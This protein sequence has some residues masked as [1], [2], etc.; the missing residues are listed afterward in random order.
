MT[1]AAEGA[2]EGF[3]SAHDPN[4]LMQGE[5]SAHSDSLHRSTKLENFKI[6]PLEEPHAVRRRKI[7]EKY[8]EITK[9]YR[10][11]IRS[12]IFCSI[13]VIIQ[14][15]MMYVVRDWSVVPLIL[16][17]YWVSGTLNHSLFLAMHE[18]THD[19][20]FESRWANKIFSYIVNIPMGVP[21][22]VY[23]RTYH[24]L[25]H[26]NL[27][28]LGQD[29]DIPSVFE[30]KIFRGKLGKLVW[31]CLQSATYCLR[32]LI[33]KPLPTTRAIVFATVF[34]YGLDLVILLTLG[35]KSLFYLFMG[36]I[37]GGAL[38]PIAGHFIAE[39]FE[40]IPGQSTYSYY[41]PLNWL[42]YNAGYHVEHHDFPRIPGS[43]LPL[44][45]Q[46][47]PEWYD[48]PSYDSWV[49]VLYDFV[50]NDNMTLFTRATR[51]VPV[52]PVTKMYK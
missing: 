49:R 32:P 3:K 8:P 7:L 41:G 15:C 2:S 21:A 37:M 38:H 30:G 1:V 16:I 20:F 31:L 19:L 43:K 13:T 22:S 17:T 23:F 33:I 25:H 40:F 51:S 46:I 42:V 11:D 52:T 35:W 36:S 12:A 24:G 45:K 27:G 29:T 10:H 48:L 14:L 9:L 44:L 6:S 28:E 26:T 50:M 4:S 47:A 39:H 34:H 5:K 18:V